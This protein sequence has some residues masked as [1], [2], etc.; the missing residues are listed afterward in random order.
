MNSQCMHVNNDYDLSL[1]RPLLESC[2][3]RSSFKLR[4]FPETSKPFWFTLGTL[5]TLMTQTVWLYI[6]SSFTPVTQTITRY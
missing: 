6:T 2:H 1:A 4:R 5:N 3:R